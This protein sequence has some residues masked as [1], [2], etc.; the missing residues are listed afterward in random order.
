MQ[1]KLKIKT[2]YYIIIYLYTNYSLQ[3][4]CFQTSNFSIIFFINKKLKIAQ[5][6]FNIK[7]P[8]IGTL[9]TTFMI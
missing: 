9:A 8:A 6:I 2:D 5:N 1:K 4:I 7:V 3:Y